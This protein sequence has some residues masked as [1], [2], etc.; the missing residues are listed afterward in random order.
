MP[1]EDLHDKQKVAIKAGDHSRFIRS[2]PSHVQVGR[3]LMITLQY[4][5]EV[6]RF[7]LDVARYP[8]PI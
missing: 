4:V 7:D 8:S 1:R 2:H 3:V 5:E 6:S